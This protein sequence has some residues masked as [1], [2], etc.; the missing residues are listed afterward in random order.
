MKLII[1]AGG[2][3]GHISPAVELIKLIKNKY[4][5]IY[6]MLVAT[7][8]DKNFQIIKN[9]VCDEKLFIECYSIKSSI[10]KNIINLK[11]YLELRKL[12]K[13]KQITSAIGFGGYISGLGIKA[14]QSLKLKTFIHEQNSILG[15]SNKLVLK[16]VNMMYLSFPIN[17]FKQTTLVG[18]PVYFKAQSIK[19]NIYK[20][21]N[22]VLFTSGT[23]G[24]KEINQ[25]AVN[26]ILGKH[27]TN[28][29]VT[30]IT[31]KKY[32][33][34][35]CKILKNTSTKIYEFSNSLIE[36]MASSEIVI[37]RAGSGSLFEIIG[38]NTLSIIIPSPNVTNNHQYYN[39]LYF[40]NLECIE[41]IEEK[42]LSINNFLMKFNNL[43]ANKEKYYQNM[44]ILKIDNIID[45]MIEEIC[46]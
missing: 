6:I 20:E 1:F 41:M 26:L 16:K 34:D 23:L 46:K 27:L 33:K 31:G 17:K 7:K 32:Y 38:T 13:S 28:Y 18:N 35:V 45:K 8:K 9:C 42:D 22:K 11:A 10:K 30:I 4:Q 15:L 19:K 2:T 39:A 40:K 5:N 12:M 21:R 14:A 43:I 37:S 24:A 25:L 44:S 29:D 3:L 36:Q